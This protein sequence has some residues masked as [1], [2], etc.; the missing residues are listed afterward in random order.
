M[1]TKL[2]WALSYA[3]R[4]WKVFPTHHMVGMTCSCQTACASPGKHPRTPHGALDATTDERQ[5]REWWSRWPE[6]NIAVATGK[7]SGL[8]VLD[9]DNTRSVD[10]GGGV[11]ISEG[12]NSLRTL[13]ELYEPLPETLQQQTGSGGRHFFFRYPEEGHYRNRARVLPSIDVRADGGY[14]IV[15]P[16]NH[17]SGASYQWLNDAPLA[18]PPGWLLDL[19]RQQASP[20][21]PEA[22][23]TKIL[24]GSRNTWLTSLAGRLREKYCLDEADLFGILMVRNQLHCAPPLP[25]QEVRLIARSVAR[26][27]C[28]EPAPVLALPEEAVVYPVIQPG[29]DLAPDLA[30]FLAQPV[31][32]PEPLVTGLFD[33]GTGIVIG[34]RPNVGKSWLVF[35][36]AL[37]V[38]SGTPWLGRETVPARVLIV[39]E[40][41]SPWATQSRL[42]RL[43]AGRGLAPDLPVWIVIGRRLR[44]DDETGLTTFRRLLERYRPDLVIYDSLVRAHRGDENAAP[45]MAE[46]FDLAKQLM[47]T[48]ETAFL[49][50]HHVRKPSLLD[51]EHPADWLR[52]SS[53]INAWPDAVLVLSEGE[54]PGLIRVDHAKARDHERVPSMTV[55]LAVTGTDARLEVVGEITR[56]PWGAASMQQAVLDAV[57]RLVLDGREATVATVAA[58][59]SRSPDTVRGYLKMLVERGHLVQHTRPGKQSCYLLAR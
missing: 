26:Y 23:E 18:D 43:L 7:E 49:F 24:P 20:V 13:A 32:A 25:A 5:I 51:A 44:L 9:V 37:A 10:V 31:P 15:P 17:K 22:G 40:E 33:R 46:F 58:E 12:E 41:G 38:A 42:A 47:T 53:E 52:G 4:G 56:G 29:A 21:E 19:L 36:L 54:E 48:Y 59:L 8:L 6:A 55:R 50:T 16:S 27:P 1:N 11:L 2:D 35:D 3:S 28:S 45:D 34:G 39:D 14:V 57:A 30:S